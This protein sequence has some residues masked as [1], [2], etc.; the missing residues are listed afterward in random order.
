MA[1]ARHVSNEV[2]FMENGV[3]V[4]EGPSQDFFQHPRE[5]RTR[6]F[7]QSF[8]SMRERTHD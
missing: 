5:A 3:I 8:G 2:I 4:E 7:L 1:I 6:A